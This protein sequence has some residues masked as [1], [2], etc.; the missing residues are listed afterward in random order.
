M[1]MIGEFVKRL[2]LELR[3]IIEWALGHWAVTLIALV[4]LIYWS[5]RQKRFRRHHL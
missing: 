5:A 3:P 2:F 1:D 4:A